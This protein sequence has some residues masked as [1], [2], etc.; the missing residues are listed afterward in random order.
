MNEE[1]DNMDEQKNSLFKCIG[2]KV[3]YYR[4]LRGLTQRELAEK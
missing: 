4:T 3:T 2:A 1:F